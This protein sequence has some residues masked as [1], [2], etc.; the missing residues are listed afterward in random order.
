MSHEIPQT[1][2]QLF[3]DQCLAAPVGG[4]PVRHQLF[5]FAVHR[6]EAEWV[7]CNDNPRTTQELG[8]EL[9]TDA[10]LANLLLNRKFKA[11]PLLP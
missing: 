9:E 1:D 10:E 7:L 2:R 8:I 5:P 4:M 11:K 6:Y 3:L